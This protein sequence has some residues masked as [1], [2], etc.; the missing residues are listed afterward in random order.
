MRL[1]SVPPLQTVSDGWDDPSL[2]K[3]L[4]RTEY[5]DRDVDGND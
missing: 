3:G 4:M 2:H 5:P 1:H